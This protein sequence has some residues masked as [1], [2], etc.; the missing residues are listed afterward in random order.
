MLK[1]IA[2]GVRGSK[3]TITLGPIHT[4]LLTDLVD[5]RGAEIEVEMISTNGACI[6]KCED[7]CELVY[8]SSDEE[9]EIDTPEPLTK[10]VKLGG[11]TPAPARH[12]AKL[13][14]KKSEPVKTEE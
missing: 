2:D 9:E 5:K 7:L 13:S 14:H 11:N 8:G 1:N 10:S 12:K 6:V 4:Q 3:G